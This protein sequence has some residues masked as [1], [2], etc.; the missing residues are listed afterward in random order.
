MGF[1]KLDEKKKEV[2]L[3]CFFGAL[4]TLI[5][6]V[7]YNLCFYLLNINNSLSNVISWVVSV[8][9]AYVTNK[10]WVFDS[11]SFKISVIISEILS[12]FGCRLATG[13]IDILI[14]YIAVDRLYLTAWILKILSNIIVIILNYVASKF[15]IFKKQKGEGCTK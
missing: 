15:F 9:F 12:F 7:I 1:L 6:I 10:V 8:I 5:N 4:T 2:L 13:V 14:M 3:Y 11:R